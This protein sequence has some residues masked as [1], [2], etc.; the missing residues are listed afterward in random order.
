MTV[1][2]LM[3]RAAQLGLRLGDLETIDTGLLLDMLTEQSNDG[4]EYPS[5]AVQGDFDR[6]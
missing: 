1:G 4:Y 6:F 5:R 2:L 3:L